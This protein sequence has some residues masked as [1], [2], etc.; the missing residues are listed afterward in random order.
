LREFFTTLLITT[1]LIFLIEI[2]TGKYFFGS[3]LNC[4]YLRCNQEY[5]YEINFVSEGSNNIIN[6]SRDKNGFRGIRKAYNQVDFLVM[7][8]STTDEKFQDEKNTW[9]EKLE[10]KFLDD[11][12]DVDFV[13]AGVEGQS[14]LGH[15]YN[16]EN[17]FFEIDQLKPKFIVFYIGINEGRSDH[18]LRYD[19]EP[20]D[21]LFQ[22]VKFIIKKNN[23]LLIKLYRKI[24]NKYFSNQI[25]KSKFNFHRPNVE[26]EFTKIMKPEDS[27]VNLEFGKWINNMFIKR[28]KKLSEYSEKMGSTPIFISQRSLRWFIKDGILYEVDDKDIENNQMVNSYHFKE[29]KLSAAME[30]FAIKNNIY[31]IN[32]FELLNLNET[33]LYDYTHTNV[34]GSE[35]I[36][37]QLYPYVK[38]IYLNSLK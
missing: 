1:L 11:G 18:Y 2:L 22:K 37:D 7:G 30:D 17:W 25:P 19:N 34:K 32:G 31:F 24:K 13:N 26:R 21:N 33:L 6:Y 14:T 9:T 27:K 38:N 12:I 28:L 3:G 29:K 15:I 36:S 16:F 20:K 4:D 8:G 35:Y 5:T 23:G 10:L